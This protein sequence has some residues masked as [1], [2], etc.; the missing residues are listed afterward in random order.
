MKP[1]I[2]GATLVWVPLIINET[3]INENVRLGF[4]V[5]F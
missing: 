5:L 2:I 1:T 4:R 3:V